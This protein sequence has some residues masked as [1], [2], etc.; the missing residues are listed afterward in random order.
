MKK[1]V[2]AA[3]VFLALWPS[4][5]R[6]QSN[7]QADPSLATTWDFIA[8]LLNA[9]GRSSR[10][11]SVTNANH[12]QKVYTMSSY[13]ITNFQAVECW[14][15]Y[16]AVASQYAIFADDDGSIQLGSRSKS[17][18]HVDLDAASIV[19]GSVRTHEGKTVASTDE[20]GGI[21]SR[22]DWTHV[23]FR[24]SKSMPLSN[25]VTIFFLAPTRS[26]SER[27]VTDVAN[28]LFWPA[29]DAETAQRLTNALN[30]AVELCGKHDNFVAAR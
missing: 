29:K 28:E 25:H 14:V 9:D 24:L 8:Q 30:T 26:N 10:D 22:T 15:S 3:L 12:I 13:R 18:G 1:A 16:D 7:S 27:D 17:Q 20:Q 5:S 23:L 6:A 2:N 11:S 21:H 19:K 4:I